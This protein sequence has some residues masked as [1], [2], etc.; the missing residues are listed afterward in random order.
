M[1]AKPGKGSSSA[2]SER[3][4]AAVHGL[5]GEWSPRAATRGAE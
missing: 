1:F 5:L 4:A 2:G 3:F